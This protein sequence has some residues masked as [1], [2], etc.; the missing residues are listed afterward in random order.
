MVENLATLDPRVQMG[1]SP[2]SRLAASTRP[3][4]R[5]SGLIYNKECA[6]GVLRAV[7]IGDGDMANDSLPFVWRDV[8]GQPE[9]HACSLVRPNQLHGRPI[10][11]GVMS[12]VPQLNILIDSGCCCGVG[13][14]CGTGF[15]LP[16]RVVLLELDELAHQLAVLRRVPGMYAGLGWRISP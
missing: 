16:V 10:A 9:A 15:A 11:D 1:G 12:T 13:C 5:M 7:A 8:F 2:P 6:K 4:A 3:P 14:C